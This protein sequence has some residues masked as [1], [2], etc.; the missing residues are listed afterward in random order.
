M[1]TYCGGPFAFTSMGGGQR[2]A[3]VVALGA[4]MGL[5]I[6]RVVHIIIITPENRGISYVWSY[7]Y[8]GVRD[9][10]RR[11]VERTFWLGDRRGRASIA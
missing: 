1:F 2:G 8:S 5:T 9:L 10:S 11:A 4:L 7:D 3:S 6:L